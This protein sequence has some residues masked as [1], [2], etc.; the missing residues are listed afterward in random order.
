MKKNIVIVSCASTGLNYIDDIK[1]RG[2]NPV[3][4]DAEPVGNDESIKP[5]ILEKENIYNSIDKNIPVIKDYK[6]YE[7]LLEKVKAYDPLLVVVGEEFGVEIGTQ[8]AD[9]LGLPGTPRERIPYMTEK[10]KMHQTLKEH[11]LRCIEGKIISSL[12]DAKEFF[13]SL[14]TQDFVIKWSRGAGTQGVH[15]CHGWEE[16]KK[17]VEDSLNHPFFENG[18]KIE[19]LMQEC[20]KGDEYI[21]NTIT[22]NGQHRVTSVLK[23]NKI[24]LPDGSHVYN[25]ANTLSEIDIGISN[26]IRYAY[27]TVDAIGIVNGPVHGE[28][29][30][31]ERG[32]VLMEVNCRPMGGNMPRKFLESVFGHHETDV[33]LDT[34]LHPEHFEE[35]RLQFYRPKRKGCL[36]VFIVPENTIANTAPILQIAKNLKS[37][38]SAHLRWVGRE[39]ELE[40]TTDLENA[41]GYVYLIH[42]DPRVVMDDTNLLHLIETKYPKLFFDNSVNS[43]N[44]CKKD[45]QL[46]DINN[47]IKKNVRK[48]S[49][50]VLTDRNLK[51]DSAVVCDFDSLNS[52]YDGFEQGVLDL[53]KK[54]SFKDLESTIERIFKFASKIREGGRII[55]PESTYENLPYGIE[56]IEILMKTLN[57]RIEMPLSGDGRLFIASKK[58]ETYESYSK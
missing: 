23:Y 52:F 31:D 11:G 24:T 42:E 41:G 16:I 35:E 29:M 3:I 2:Y 28:Y 50:L 26:L 27:D 45:V 51:L 13:D 48:G 53:T 43:D 7:E 30:V 19:L 20:I 22:C 12:D 44:S 1:Y 21:V 57:L 54:S 9:D 36:K 34:Y 5:I 47:L 14:P 10:A 32:P 4:V 6:N 40:K 37:Y 38:H 17:A 15:I 18:Q 39:T 55:V 8:L 56:G 46:C 49:T 33:I 25:Y 58:Y